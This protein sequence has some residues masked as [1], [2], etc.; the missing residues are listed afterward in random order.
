MSPSH[1]GLPVLSPCPGCGALFPPFD[2]PTH[3]YVGASAG[4]WA[5][6]SWALVSAGTDAVG[7]AAQ[8]RIPDRPVPVPALSDTP[9][10][11][12]LC[13]DAY[14]VQHHGNDSPQAIQS[15]AGHLLNIHGIISGKTTRPRWAIDRA[16]RTRG[17]FHKL[18]PPAL[19]S[20]LTFRHFFPG[21]GVVTPIAR[22][23]YVVSVY[24][25]WMAL[26]RSTVE[27]WW[28]RY[29]APDEVAARDE[30]ESA[31]ASSKRG[32]AARSGAA[33]RRPRDSGGRSPS[34]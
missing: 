13:G 5:L 7:L 14:G 17:V 23:Q 28:E 4:C 2:G 9:P 6:F 10:I 22:S 27:Q 33:G 30:P 11:D 25:S 31:A 19:G 29:V 20:A 18:A 1:D 12:M 24:E 32:A 26:H 34:R 21:G 16:L 8:S 15:V 3:R